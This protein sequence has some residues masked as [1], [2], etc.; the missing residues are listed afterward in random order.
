MTFIEKWKN[1]KAAKKNVSIKFLIKF[2][3]SMNLRWDK[4]SSWQYGLSFSYM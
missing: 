1:S 4:F 3:L 2:I